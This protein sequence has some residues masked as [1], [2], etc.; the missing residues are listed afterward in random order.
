MCGIFASKNFDLNKNDISFIK[1]NLF[2]RG[3]E[4]N[5]HA[6][7]ENKVNFIHTR[8]S[9]LEISNFGNQPMSDK[10]NQVTIIF[11][12]EIYNH[13]DLRE[14]IKKKINVNFKG[15]SDTETLLQMYLIYKYEMLKHLNGIFAFCIYDHRDKSIFIARDQFGVKPLYYFNQDEQ[16]IFCSEI[17]PILNICK[18]NISFD[19][20]EILK[21]LPYLFLPNDTKTPFKGI[22]KL[23]P[24]SALIINNENKLKIFQYFDHISLIKINSEIK[25]KYRDL[26]D[27]L[28]QA[29]SRQTISDVPLS[30]FLSGGLDSS[31]IIHFLNELNFNKLNSFTIRNINDSINSEG[32]VIDL[33]YAQE[34]AKKYDSNL[35]T[36]DVDKN[37]L[38]HID[39]LMNILEEPISDPAPFNLLRLSMK[40]KEL[41]MKVAFSGAGGDEVFAGY[42]RHVGAKY[43]YIL[44][45][46]PKPILLI[47]KNIISS[48]YLKSHKIRRINKLISS[49][50]N[51]NETLLINFY[52]WLDKDY[53][54]E[55]LLP[56]IK[57]Y[58]NDDIFYEDM[59][60]ILNNNINNFGN[61][62]K[63]L[64]LDL[65][66]F[67][68][69]HNLSYTDKIGMSQSLEIR[70]PMLD[71]DLV[72]Y[73]FSVPEK[74]KINLFKTKILLKKIMKNKLPNK[75]INRSK[76]GFN[77]PIRSLVKNDI[78]FHD[79]LLNRLRKNNI[80][81][82]EGVKNLYKLNKSNKVDASYSLYSILCVCSWHDQFK[83]KIA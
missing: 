11:N 4:N 26:E 17:K 46:L 38:S 10:N 79:I 52:H 45:F 47:I 30:V 33:P 5:G 83:N 72:E 73:A 41:G 43:S 76:T 19:Y 53:I 69:E 65:K 62:N 60:E 42:R 68:S 3:P 27:C 51:D 61:L 2:H 74:N 71:R 31:A 55:I 28:K 16:F 9:I 12:G 14:N 50:L 78:Y 21:Y 64:I 80:F 7:F 1:E 63:A 13:L 59:K 35:Y 23:K 58:F 37:F 24:G 54:Y 15:Y 67:M 77:S 6:Y 18:N 44:N 22:K 66:Y 57:N 25:K 20:P 49:Y 8:L 39:N 40:A 75:I 56:S 48:K 81:D 32:N 70:V 34:V 29:I 36:V 82:E